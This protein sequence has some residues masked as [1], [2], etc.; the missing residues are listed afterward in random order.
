[1]ESKKGLFETLP[2]LFFIV[3]AFHFLPVPSYCQQ[4]RPQDSVQHLPNGTDGLTFSPR[5]SDSTFLKVRNDLPFNEFTGIYSTFKIGIGYIGDATT[6]IQDDVFKQQMDSAGLSLDPKFQTRDFRA[7]F[8]GR[9]LK[10]KRFLSYRFA[11][12]YDGDKKTWLMRETGVTVGV[13]ELQGH[14]F[15]WTHQRGIFNDQSDEWPLRY[16]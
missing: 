8:S 13:P 4:V 15:Y 1:M 16:R 12:M 11:Y 6:Y 14:F 2:L 7:I 10:S 3:A 9:V 5:E